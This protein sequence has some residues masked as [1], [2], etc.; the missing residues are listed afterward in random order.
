MARSW[1]TTRPA[2]SSLTA[3]PWSTSPCQ[4]YIYNLHGTFTHHHTRLEN[5]H[6]R[7]QKLR[8]AAR[9]LQELYPEGPRTSWWE[10][11]SRQLYQFFLIFFSCQACLSSGLG[12]D[13]P[14]MPWFWDLTPKTLI[15][16]PTLSIPNIL[17]L[18]IQRV[19][20]ILG[21]YETICKFPYLW[22]WYY[23]HDLSSG[24]DLIV[25]LNWNFGIWVKLFFWCDYC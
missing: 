2:F 4:V 1:T 22:I 23:G 25:F 14:A 13:P 10:L 9:Q 8:W 7:L 5:L 21:H 17:G 24:T 20:D 16:H 15:N 19:E 6:R 18:K 3:S 11:K 12:L